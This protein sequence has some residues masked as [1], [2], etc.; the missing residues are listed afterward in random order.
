[1]TEE[2]RHKVSLKLERDLI[3]KLI[4]GDIKLNELYIDE[5]NEEESEKLGP[6]PSR[7]LASAVMG[8][9]SSSFLFCLKKKD[10][11]LDDFEAEAEIV[12]ARN[13]KGSLRIKEINVKLIPTTDSEE[14][15]ERIQTC[16]K[17]FEQFCTVTASVRDG[18]NVNVNVET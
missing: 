17:I 9:L 14:V 3:F 12:G 11:Y 10:L 15:K 16:I 18:I 6:S 5:T 8:C 2:F 1:M 13:E 4:M 7:L